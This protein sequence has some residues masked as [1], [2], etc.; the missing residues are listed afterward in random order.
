[1][2]D[3]WRVVATLAATLAGACFSPVSE[4]DYWRFQQ[5]RGDGGLVLV[6]PD[7]GS[8]PIV[9]PI[10][11]PKVAC[12]GY[13]TVENI[14]G[15]KAQLST[16]SWTTVAKPTSVCLPASHDFTTSRTINLA[17]SDIAPPLECVVAGAC[18][19]TTFLLSDE[20]EGVGCLDDFCTTLMLTS[21]RFRLRLIV[22]D[23]YPDIPRYVP[24]AEILPSCQAA[25]EPNELRC[26]AH[27]TCWKSDLDFCRFCVAA[28]QEECACLGK[29]ETDA[30]QVF[31][32]NDMH[33]SGTCRKDRCV[34]NAGQPNCPVL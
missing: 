15:L 8:I 7:G 12:A 5:M 14:E 21:A 11:C 25:C 30:C 16:L 26:S 27:D 20:A 19:G 32:T 23:Q 24:I 28:P 17:A 29:L 6:Y 10:G 3:A 31:V 4:P 18:A 22:H 33:C 13:G 34:I 9:E 1:M 2:R